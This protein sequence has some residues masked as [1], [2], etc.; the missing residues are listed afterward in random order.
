MRM[1]KIWPHLLLDSARF[2]L[3]PR[4]SPPTHRA[5]KFLFRSRFRSL[6]SCVCPFLRVASPKNTEQIRTQSIN[7]SIE[8]TTNQSINQSNDRTINQSIE[9]SINQ[10]IE[11]SIRQPHLQATILLHDHAHKGNGEKHR[12]D[13]G[14]HRG[15]NNLVQQIDGDDNLQQAAPQ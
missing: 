13:A 11:H 1:T 2:E 15:S 8:Q 12:A 6:A 7:Q 10:S 4:N 5:L 3:D 14:K 9:K